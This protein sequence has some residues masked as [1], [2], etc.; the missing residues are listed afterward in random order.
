MAIAGQID[1]Y[2]RGTIRSRRLA[3]RAARRALDLAAARTIA[4]SEAVLNGDATIQEWRR[5]FWAELAAAAALAAIERGFGH[6][7]G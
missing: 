6:F 3:A 7:R 2:T 5:A 1:V 4:A